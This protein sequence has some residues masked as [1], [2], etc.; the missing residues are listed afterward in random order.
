MHRKDESTLCTITI[1]RVRNGMANLTGV[2][3]GLR[4]LYMVGSEN[5]SVLVVN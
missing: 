1:G 3:E 5:A 2:V 4:K